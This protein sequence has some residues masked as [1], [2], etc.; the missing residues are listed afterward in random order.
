MPV[1]RLQEWP[2]QD[3]LHTLQRLLDKAPKELCSY[4]PLFG[5]AFQDYIGARPTTRLP[6]HTQLWC[7]SR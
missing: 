4:K 2:D 3:T 5:A 6:N 7:G 1:L